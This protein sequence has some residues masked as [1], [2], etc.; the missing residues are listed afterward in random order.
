MNRD[1]VHSAKHPIVAHPLPP[2]ADLAE[3]E[4]NE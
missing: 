4:F 3:A 1:L 2:L